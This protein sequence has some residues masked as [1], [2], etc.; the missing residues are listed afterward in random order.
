MVQAQPVRADDLVLRPSSVDLRPAPEIRVEFGRKL[1][2][3][4]DRQ[5]AVRVD[6]PAISVEVAQLRVLTRWKTIRTAS[7]A[8]PTGLEA[9][10]AAI[11]TGAPIPSSGG[12]STPIAR[13]RASTPLI[14]A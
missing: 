6:P 13:N 8:Q 7:A 3:V 12:T 4:V 9:L 10:N 1:P 5:V 14:T 11:A 2:D